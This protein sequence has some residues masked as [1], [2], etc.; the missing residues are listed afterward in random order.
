MTLETFFEKFELFA[1]APNAVAKMRGLIF[2]LAVA[3]KLCHLDTAEWKDA[4]LG[5]VVELISGQHLLAHEHNGEKRGIPYLT[6]PSDFGLR[7]PVPTR[8]T[9]QP[10]VIAQPGDS[11]ITVKGSGVGK[12]NVLVDEPTAVSR[13][14][15]AIR[16]DDADRDFV[17]LALRWAAEHFQNAKTGIAIPGIGRREVLGLKPVRKH[18]RGAAVVESLRRFT[19]H[20]STTCK[21][22]GTRPSSKLVASS[23]CPTKSLLHRIPTILLADRCA[24][25]PRPHMRF[26]ATSCF[27]SHLP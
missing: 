12:T 4:I 24:A 3:G 21:I 10:K 23:P 27:S 9:E 8:W 25:N 17:H 6:G 5:D 15:M 14:L 1:D 16:V 18:E 11:L 22:P 7:H 20:G 19:T 13:Q 26:L 2:E